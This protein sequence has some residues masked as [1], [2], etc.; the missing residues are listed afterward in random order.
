MSSSA[1][2]FSIKEFVI[3]I[4]VQIVAQKRWSR[5]KNFV[6][7]ILLN[8]TPFKM[9]SKYFALS[10]LA[11]TSLAAPFPIEQISGVVDVVGATETIQAEEQ[12]PALLAGAAGTLLKGAGGAALAKGVGSAAAGTLAKGVG[13]AAAGTLAKG[14]GTAAAG[15]LAKGAGNAAAGTLAKGIGGSAAA[16]LAPKAAGGASGWLPSFGSS[17]APAAGSGSSGWLPSFGSSTV[18]KAP[19][20]RLLAARS[21]F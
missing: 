15:Q 8:H 2:K 3:L 18:P 16:G 12:L 19:L 4:A 7:P 6:Q 5:N 17:T 20:G 21:M 1:I 14:V 9:L 13:S 10:L 11:A